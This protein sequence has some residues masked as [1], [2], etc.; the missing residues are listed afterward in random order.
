MPHAGICVGGCWATGIPTATST[1][2]L[3]ID[4]LALVTVS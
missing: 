4:T 1:S 2:L 3:Y